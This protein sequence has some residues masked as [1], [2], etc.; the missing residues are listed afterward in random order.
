MAKSILFL[1]F[2]FISFAAMYERKNYGKIWWLSNGYFGS[3][4]DPQKQ[5]CVTILVFNLNSNTA[6]RYLDRKK[7]RKKFSPIAMMMIM[8]MKRVRGY[9]KKGRTQFFLFERGGVYCFVFFFNFIEKKWEERR[10]CPCLNH[11]QNK[12]N[13]QW[14]FLLVDDDDEK[15][16]G[17][18]KEILKLFAMMIDRWQYRFHVL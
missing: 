7:R 2:K 1:Q 8:M 11:H 12:Y 17:K 13:A 3:F 16:I 15:K 5:K 10:G 6:Q 14:F 18:N 9:L 4:F